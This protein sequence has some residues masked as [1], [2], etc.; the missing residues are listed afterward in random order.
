MLIM[1]SFTSLAGATT[2]TT[3]L[4][5]EPQ[6]FLDIDS[7]SSEL[8]TVIVELEEQSIVE[9]KQLGK[10]QTHEK[11]AAKRNSIIAEMQKVATVNVGNKYDYVFSGFAV[12]VAEN[13]I[14]ALLEIP[15]IKAVYPDVTYEVEQISVDRMF[16]P[17]LV[18]PNMMDSAPFI[19]ANDAWAAGV[20][21]K[22]VTVAIID[23]GVDYT[24]PDLEHAFGDYKGYDFVDGNDDPQETI[25]GRLDRRTNHGTHV[26]G[27]VAANGQI[28]G[29]APDATLLAYRVLGPGG[30]G[31][32]QNVIAGIER[33]VLDGA[34]VMNLSL[35]NATNNPDFATSLALDRAMADGVVAVTSNG[36]SGPNNWT[37]GSPGT[38][39]EAIS[40]GA[41]M[42][43]YNLYSASIGAAYPSA[44]V[45][46]YPSEDELIALN[47]QT[48]ELVDVGLAGTDADFAGKDLEGKIALMR[49]GDYAFVDKAQNAK[50]RGA[51]G[52][53]IYNNVPGVQPEVPGT[54]IPMIMLTQADGQAL[55]AE[56]QAGNNTIT[57]DIAFVKEVGETMA[58]FS[59]RGP[60]M[61][62]WMIKPDVSAPGVAIVSTVPVH[63]SSGDH[64]HGYA[65]FQG[66]SMAAPHVAGAA[67]LILQAHPDW[68]VDFVKAA[69]MNTAENLFDAN[70]KLYPHNSQG[71]G[72]IRVLDAINTTVLATPG[73][74]SFGI[75]TKFDGK[76]VRNQ[77]FTVHNLSDK[78]QKFDIE[79]TG[80]EGIKVMTSKNLNVQPGS[81]QE[82]NY[83][84]QVDVKNLP[85][86]YYEGTFIL[87]SGDLRIEVPTIVFVQ[88]PEGVRLA[89]W[90]S[91]GISGG[92][93]VGNVNLPFGA[94]EFN[95][96][97]RS[98]ATGA[99]LREIP[100]G[101]NLSSG[102]YGITWDMTVNGEAL[103]PGR[104]QVIAYVKNGVREQEVVGGTLNVN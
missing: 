34:D 11:I 79:F 91:I 104:Y 95:V 55:L 92:N 69:L 46:G 10:K 35:G 1:S 103:A 96:R 77:S 21:G 24:H 58:N 4:T 14:P 15:G 83:R 68:S 76:E 26:A 98:E 84:V 86:G 38:S 48:I 90:E 53:V 12:E 56:V 17:E 102:T 75:F 28:K 37:V 16:D 54:A 31:T 101:T 80:H 100:Y 81:T 29:V 36:N 71:A 30:S 66:T 93:V 23:T 88:I 50:D 99:L 41:T 27:T 62:N 25:G 97:I 59:S 22:G 8:I 49:R 39:R 6:V 19:G 87:T 82:L 73:S 51:I 63:H 18:S 33:A 72:S 43:P 9:A 13:N 40:V 61:G 45:M 89:T 7:S 67:A 32:T 57:F 44:A 20:T 85:A 52:A 47:G 94:D 74:H 78:R 5:T 2:N 65:A 42:L 3:T 60:V 64:T 70:D